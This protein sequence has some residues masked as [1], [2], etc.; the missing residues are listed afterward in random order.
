MSSDRPYTLTPLDGAG[1]EIRF[2]A[3]LDP[4]HPIFGGHFPAQPVLPGVCTLA[5]LRDAIAR[6]EGHPVRFD[7]I[8]ECKFT[9]PVDPRTTESLELRM[10]ASGSEVRATVADRE[11]IVLKLKATYTQQD[12]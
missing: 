1:P 10:T 5:M 9:A 12:E 11:R 7:R 3:R 2:T 8:R 6:T 4:S